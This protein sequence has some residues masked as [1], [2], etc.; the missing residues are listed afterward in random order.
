MGMVANRLR[1]LHWWRS[2]ARLIY[3]SFEIPRNMQLF[4]FRIFI[5]L[6]IFLQLSASIVYYLLKDGTKKV[7]ITDLRHENT[8][9]VN[10]IVIDFVFPYYLEFIGE[11][12]HWSEMHTL[13]I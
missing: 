11:L 13:H 6:S 2:N 10:K 5:I 8:S 4:R 1:I 9:N 3:F 12:R 7:K